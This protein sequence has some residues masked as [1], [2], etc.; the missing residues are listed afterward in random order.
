MSIPR[1]VTLRRFRRFRRIVGFV[2]FVALAEDEK[3][4]SEVGFSAVSD[5]VL[6]LPPTGQLLEGQLTRYLN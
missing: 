2:A 6:G 3:T 5:V 1:S 4:T